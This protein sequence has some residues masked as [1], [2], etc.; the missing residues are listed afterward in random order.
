MEKYNEFINQFLSDL[1]TN[2][3]CQM[4]INNLDFRAKEELTYKNPIN[5]N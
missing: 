5:L 3:S 4:E 2:V 1:E